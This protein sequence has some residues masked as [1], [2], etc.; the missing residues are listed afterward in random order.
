MKD[1]WIGRGRRGQSSS[2]GPTTRGQ[3]GGGRS[4]SR[5]VS[6]RQ[7]TTEEARCSKGF[8]VGPGGSI[9]SCVLSV[10]GLCLPAVRHVPEAGRHRS[11][12][13]VRHR[14]VRLVGEGDR[15]CPLADLRTRC[16]GVL[17]HAPM[18]VAVGCRVCGANRGRHAGME[19]VGRQRSR[20][21][22]GGADRPHL[23]DP[24]SGTV[25]GKT[26][27]RGACGE[28]PGRKFLAPFR[29]S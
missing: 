7:H 4:G 20:L 16:V 13:V 25:A 15:T 27:V 10:H 3:A 8:E 2:R 28:P 1:S 14:A 22:G 19:R 6:R 5:L 26:A 24:D 21:D 12:G 17:G 29:T 18:D 11:R 23:H 9:S